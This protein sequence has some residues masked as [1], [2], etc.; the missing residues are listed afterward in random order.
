[1]VTAK[2]VRDA[3]KQAIGEGRMVA[4]DDLPEYAVDGVMPK[5]AVFPKNE[6]Q[7]GAVLGVAAREGWAVVPRGSGRLMGLGSVPERVDIVVGLERL[8]HFIEHAPEDLTV[9]V[10]AGMTLGLLQEALAMEGQWLSLDPPLASGRTVGG[11][12]ATDLNGPLSFGYGTARD[13]VLGMK[14]VG[15][16]GVVTKSGGRVVKNVTGF[17][18]AKVH[19]GGLGTLGIIVEA[20][21]RLQPLP[22]KDATLT[23]RFDSLDG[24]MEAACEMADPSYAPQA[25]EVVAD[26][27]VRLC[28]RF[29]GSASGV[30]RRLK[31]IRSLLETAGSNGV[32]MLEGVEAG[33]L[34]QR[35]SDFGWEEK[36]KKSLMLRLGCLPS[37]VGEVAAETLSLAEKRGYKIGM[38]IGPGRGVLRCVFPGLDRGDDT[39]ISGVVD[40]SRGVVESVGGYAVVEG[41]PTRAK[42]RLDVW[43]DAGPGLAVMH[44]LKEQM[45]P[46]R[47]LNPGRF[48]GGI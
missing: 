14:V 13:M 23:A 44:R 46:S 48:L 11:V 30:E 41:C 2:P 10:G 18:V 28:A 7:L 20:S 27:R 1:V 17:D 9:T 40:G 26:D 47:I 3:L 36:P 24:A 38:V 34:W 42:K 16:D 19:V 35:I 29:L 22:R 45:D 25:L 43:G 21:F 39:V 5:A 6:D 31:D 8:E 15:A 37:R 4:D 32:E 12:L 33:E